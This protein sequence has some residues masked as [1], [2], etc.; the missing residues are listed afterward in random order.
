MLNVLKWIMWIGGGA[1]ML[2][3]V[4]DLNLIVVLCGVLILGFGSLLALLLNMEG[5]LQEMT[6]KLDFLC[7]KYGWV[8]EK[9]QEEL[10]PEQ[11]GALRREKEL[12][13]QRE[14]NQ[15]ILQAV[16]KKYPDKEWTPEQLG[17][18][19]EEERKRRGAAGGTAE[20]ETE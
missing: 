3:G 1:V 4:I 5:Q 14:E 10:T 16:R 7:E 20:K 12:Q 2:L 15:E 11:L 9:N 19:M 13:K 17:I 18:L 8:E 6:R